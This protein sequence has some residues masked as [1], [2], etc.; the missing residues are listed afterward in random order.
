[1]ISFQ[2]GI[3]MYFI[4]IY[5][6]LYT[7]T[8]GTSV[9]DIYLN[10]KIM[11]YIDEYVHN[12]TIILLAKSCSHFSSLFIIKILVRGQGP[13]PTIVNITATVSQ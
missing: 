8:Q 5:Q 7:K 6:S 2:D 11:L 13:P 4:C 10:F 12:G 1:M 9:E 3:W